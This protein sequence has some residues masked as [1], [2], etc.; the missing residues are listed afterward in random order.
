MQEIVS[1]DSQLDLNVPKKLPPGVLQITTG[2]EYELLHRGE[3]Y[4][5]YDTVFFPKIET[6]S[7]THELDIS[8]AAGQQRYKQYQEEYNKWKHMLLLKEGLM[9]KMAQI[10]SAYFACNQNGCH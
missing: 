2:D 8:S 9:C 6:P 4:L 5:T 1:K 3:F 7:L 10:K